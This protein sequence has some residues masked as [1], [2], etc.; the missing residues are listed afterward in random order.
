[1]SRSK[2]SKLNA[3]SSEDYVRFLK[4]LLLA[5]DYLRLSKLEIVAGRFVNFPDFITYDLASYFE[6]AGLF[7]LLYGL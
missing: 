5:P 6:H 3:S 7:D 4:N 2:K 1:M